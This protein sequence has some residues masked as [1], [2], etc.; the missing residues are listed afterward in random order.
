MSKLGC[1]EPQER[2][3]SLKKLFAKHGIEHKVPASQSL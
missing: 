1:F 3:R 2:L